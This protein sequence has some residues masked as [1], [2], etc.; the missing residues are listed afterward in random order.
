MSTQM[1]KAIVIERYGGVEILHEK[2]VSKPQLTDPHDLLVRVRATGVNPVDTKIRRN[3][4]NDPNDALPTSPLILGYDASGVV[5]Q[6]GS[7]VE[8][9]NP[10]DKVFY[11]GNVQRP[12]SYAQYQLVD[13]RLVG[14]MPQSLS[15][16]QAAGVPLTAL[17]AYELLH[18]RMGLKAPVGGSEE[19]DKYKQKSVLIINGAGGVGTIATQLCKHVFKLG[20]VI[21]T[22]SRPESQ[23]WCK[24]QG[25]DHT[26]D[27]RGDIS[28]Q[29][30]AIGQELVDYVLVLTH[31]EDYFERCSD[32]IKPYGKVGLIVETDKK[33]NITGQSVFN[34]HMGKCVSF[35]WETVLSRPINGIDIN[36]HGSY[37]NY[38]A[39]CFDL[40]VLHPYTSAVFDNADQMGEAHKLQESGKTTG[41]IVVKLP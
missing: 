36:L 3:F 20:C 29:L 9:F 2:E 41:K 8:N 19:E 40:G 7:A 23:E 5:E 32:W 6:V 25:A 35:H 17:T 1:M 37:L 27:H 10:G 12:G 28:E 14:K 22:A 18:H 39:E 30:R 38:I 13:S 26:V 11:M 24:N 31:T 16:E 21:A 34:G 33:L 4:G 15:F